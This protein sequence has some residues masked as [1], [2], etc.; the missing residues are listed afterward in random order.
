MSW[1]EYTREEFAGEEFAQPSLPGWTL[2]AG[3]GRIEVV[4]SVLHLRAG[5]EGG[6]RYSVL[7][8]ADLFPTDGDF[9]L[10]VSFRYSQVRPYGTTI[11]V[12]SLAYEGDRY[13]EGDPRRLASRMC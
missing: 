9:I 11:G 4:D 3:D 6:E 10:E 7:A 2:D 8:R 12:G 1:A 13:Q 5:S